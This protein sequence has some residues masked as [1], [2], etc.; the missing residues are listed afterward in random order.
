MHIALGS[1]SKSSQLSLQIL[2]LLL[3]V[4]DQSHKRLIVFFIHARLS[5]C[6]WGEIERG[7]LCLPRKAFDLSDQ[8]LQILL[9]E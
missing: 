7:G 6:G 3:E 1:M 9:V 2:N 8:V 5:F 4:L